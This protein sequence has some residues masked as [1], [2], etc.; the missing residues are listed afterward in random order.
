MSKAPYTVERIMRRKFRTPEDRGTLTVVGRFSTKDEA[1][2]ACAAHKAAETDDRYTYQVVII[3]RPARLSN[4][5][6]GM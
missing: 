1:D 4:M 2:A 3:D 5:L 6:N